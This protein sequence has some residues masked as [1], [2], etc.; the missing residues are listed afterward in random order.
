MSYYENIFKAAQT[1]TAEDVQYFINE[2]N[3]D[4]N[5]RDENENTPLHW[6]AFYANIKVVEYLISNEANIHAKNKQGFTPLHMAAFN[7]VSATDRVEVAKM[8]ISKGANVNART[9]EKNTPTALAS[10]C[11]CEEMKNY[12][13]SVSGSFGSGSLSGNNESS[14]IIGKVFLGVIIGIVVIFIIGMCSGC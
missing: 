12:L 2:K 9:N 13:L 4:K 14:G 6:S 5:A 1:G 10:D 8:L 7:S 11:N 3:I